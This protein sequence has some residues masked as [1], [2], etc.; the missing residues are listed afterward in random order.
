MFSADT[1]TEV[2]PENWTDRIDHPSI[3]N[4]TPCPKNDVSISGAPER[5]VHN[6]PVRLLR[7]S[8]APLPSRQRC[9]INAKFAGEALLSPTLACAKP[10]KSPGKGSRG[11]TRVVAQKADDRWEVTEFG[12]R[13]IELP[14]SDRK[15]MNPHA[16]PHLPLQQI[17]VNPAT[18]EVIA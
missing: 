1:P 14:I 15:A 5:S 9:R 10:L 6:C 16:L 7:C 13:P 11:W 17:E 12:C 8:F 2:D 18:A 3:E 4:R